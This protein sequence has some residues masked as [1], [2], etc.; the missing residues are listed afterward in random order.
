[1]ANTKTFRKK[2]DTKQIIPYISN[3]KVKLGEK[4]SALFAYALIFL[5]A[6]FILWGS[7][8]FINVPFSVSASKVLGEARSVETGQSWPKT[9]YIP[10]INKTLG[11][12]AGVVS[13]NR[14]TISETGVSYL[15]T[16][17]VPGSAGNS[18]LYGH[19]KQDIFGKLVELQKDDVIYVV[20]GNGNFAKYSV[21]ETKQVKPNQVEILNNTSDS[22][23]TIYTCTGFL[24]SARFVV[25]AKMV[26][27]SN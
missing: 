17:P 18:V 10:K 5:G 1:M 4:I 9:I 25:I 15:S 22:R 6:G 7:A 19:N 2:R 12:S 27:N 24:D 23:L 13:D 3:I 20:L 21:V 16:T 14:W 26:A 8:R 11:I